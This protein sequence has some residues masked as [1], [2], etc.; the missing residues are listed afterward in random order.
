MKLTNLNIK[1]KDNEKNIKC[2]EKKIN[3]FNEFILERLQEAET[4]MGNTSKRYTTNDIEDSMND[5][6]NKIK[7]YR[8][9]KNKTL[10]YFGA[11][12][13]IVEHIISKEQI[14]TSLNTRFC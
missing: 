12:T 13:K 3:T 10:H 2:N 11:Y 7:Q 4:E 6:I 9:S 5:I 1:I 14:N 8:G